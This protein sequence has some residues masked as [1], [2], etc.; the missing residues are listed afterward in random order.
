MVLINCPVPLISSSSILYSL[1]PSELEFND[2][3]RF[4]NAQ[5][6]CMYVVVHN[7]CRLLTLSSGSRE[8]ALGAGLW[9]RPYTWPWRHRYLEP[10]HTFFHSSL[11]SCS[12]PR[13]H[14]Y[15]QLRQSLPPPGT[16]SVRHFFDSASILLSWYHNL[17]SKYTNWYIWSFFIC[18]ESMQNVHSTPLKLLWVVLVLVFIMIIVHLICTCRKIRKMNFVTLR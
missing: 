9:C 12:E 3:A 15:I 7:T 16:S 13:T 17:L 1:G 6:C 10:R 11:Y 14:W 4:S 8:C 2:T 18:H 5:K